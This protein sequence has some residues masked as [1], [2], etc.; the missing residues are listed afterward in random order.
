VQGLSHEGRWTKP[1]RV[2]IKEEWGMN[3]LIYGVEFIVIAVVLFVVTAVFLPFMGELP[4]G[5]V[6]CLSAATVAGINNI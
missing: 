2:Q 6:V 4:V 5:F 1:K 3:Y